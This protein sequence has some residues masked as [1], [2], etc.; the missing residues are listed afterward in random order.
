[1]CLQVAINKHRRR[2]VVFLILAVV[3]I[4]TF[5]F[6]FFSK[7]ANY[8]DLSSRYDFNKL[9]FQDGD[10]I[11]RRGLSLSSH[12]VLLTDKK[13]RFSHVGMIRL[14]DGN[15]FVVH[16]VPGENEQEIEYLKIE[17]VTEFLD[18][19]KATLGAVYRLKNTE[20]EKLLFVAEKVESF[21][22]KKLIFDN[23]YDLESDDKMYCTEL[24]W[25]A[26]NSIGVDLT[27]GKRNKLNVP[28][29][30]TE[31]ILPS[32]IQHSSLLE[33]IYLFY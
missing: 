8:N 32:L 18:K 25:K 27:D 23:K 10:L 29:G 3:V 6:V 12:A 17:P 5:S 7:R 14:I 30:P 21:A 20:K 13:S 19:E 31:I 22:R 1:M 11:F 9:T 4:A 15:A 28:V 33:E 16:A 24:I 2:L 26:Y